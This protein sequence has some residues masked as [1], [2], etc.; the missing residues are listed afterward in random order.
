VPVSMC[1]TRARAGQLGLGE[2]AMLVE[3]ESPFTDE[4]GEAGLPA[5]LPPPVVTRSP[6]ASG[7]KPP[8]TPRDER[9]V[10]RRSRAPHRR[11]RARGG[12]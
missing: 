10:G 3:E 7:A 12:S 8:V 1:S 11:A 5:W 6:W 2:R 9:E 4:V